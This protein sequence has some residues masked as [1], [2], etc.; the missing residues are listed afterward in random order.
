MEVWF[1]QGEGSTVAET[2]PLGRLEVEGLPPG[3]IGSTTVIIEAHV[4]SESVLEVRA[5][6]QTGGRTFTS[7][8]ATRSTPEYLRAKLGLPEPPA[9]GPAA[10]AGPTRVWAWLTSLFRHTGARLG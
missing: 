10:G 9:H 6:D 7:R 3:P 2:E 1:F 4:S 5:R 8:F